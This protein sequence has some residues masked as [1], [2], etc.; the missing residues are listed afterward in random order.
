[1]DTCR[2]DV[3]PMDL[4]PQTIIDEA[5]DAAEPEDADGLGDA[6]SKT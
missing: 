2:E 5:L 1:M 6:T 4:E 3:V